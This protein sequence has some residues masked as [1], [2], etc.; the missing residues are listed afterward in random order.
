MNSVTK[1][2]IESAMETAGRLKDDS[3]RNLSAMPIGFWFAQGDLLLERLSE[4]PSG[5]KVIPADGEYQLAEG[6]TIGSHH[7]VDASTVKLYKRGGD[8]LTGPVL[9]VGSKGATITHPKHG[10]CRLP[11]GSVWGISYQRAYSP[12]GEIRRQRD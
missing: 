9:L 8:A 11:S 7:R 4:V 12:L 6:N 3:T 5:L 2:K 1:E 10:D